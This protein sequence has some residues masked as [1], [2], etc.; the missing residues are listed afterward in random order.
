MNPTTRKLLAE[1]FEELAKWLA[2]YPDGEEFTLAVLM[3]DNELWDQTA[4]SVHSG[5]GTV[6]Y[7]KEFK[8]GE[9]IKKDCYR[10]T[11]STR[12]GC[13]HQC[14]ITVLNEKPLSYI[15]IPL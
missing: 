14:E 9:C 4:S 6:F 11:F 2:K 15:A 5:A 7:N 10:I 3:K 12:D 1:I 13:Q 8:K